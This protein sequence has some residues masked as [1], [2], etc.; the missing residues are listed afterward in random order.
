MLNIHLRTYDVLCLSL[1]LFWTDGLC[2]ARAMVKIHFLDIIKV[3][4]QKKKHNNGQRVSICAYGSNFK[5]KTK[6]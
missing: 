5:A 3:S 6:M 1:L 4:Q 2:T